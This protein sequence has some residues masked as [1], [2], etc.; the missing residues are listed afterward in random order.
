M[1]AKI[2]NIEICINISVY[3]V[4][5]LN[6]ITNFFLLHILFLPDFPLNLYSL[7][8]IKG[9]LTEQIFRC[10]QYPVII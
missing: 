10:L 5:L 2:K 6:A 8:V 4:L 7:I 9:T 3:T 1:K